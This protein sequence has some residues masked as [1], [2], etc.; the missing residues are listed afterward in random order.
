MPPVRNGKHPQ[1]MRPA[2]SAQAP[3]AVGSKGKSLPNNPPPRPAI[4]GTKATAAAAS[5]RPVSVQGSGGMRSPAVQLPSQPPTASPRPQISTMRVGTVEIEV[6]RTPSQVIYRLPKDRTVNSLTPEEHKYVMEAINKLHGQQRVRPQRPTPQS[7]PQLLPSQT[8]RASLA[9]PQPAATKTY[10]ISTMTATP[11]GMRPVRPRPPS[12][13]PTQ[14]PRPLLPIQARTASLS[15]PLATSAV[16]REA[17]RPTN[18]TN[19]RG[20]AAT[21]K[22][23][24]GAEPQQKTLSAV[25]TQALIQKLRNLQNS[26]SLAGSL[27]AK[28]TPEQL[29][30]FLSTSLPMLASTTEPSS[31]QVLT[32][33][34][35]MPESGVQTPAS[36]NRPFTMP[37]TPTRGSDGQSLGTGVEKRRQSKAGGQPPKRQCMYSHGNGDSSSYRLSSPS[38]VPSCPL[39]SPMVAATLTDSAAPTGGQEE[40]QSLSSIAKRTSSPSLASASMLASTI[41][42][43]PSLLEEPFASI[44][45]PRILPCPSNAAA[46][47]TTTHIPTVSKFA[48]DAGAAADGSVTS[49]Q[50]PAS[51]CKQQKTSPPRAM[52]AIPRASPEAVLKALRPAFI[53]R[54]PRELLEA[55]IATVKSRFRAALNADYEA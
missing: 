35:S 11:T 25:D 23:Y 45:G 28:L 54:P 32:A 2:N 14:Q 34:P 24:T 46:V 12:D 22:S 27:A 39:D 8:N 50:A 47:T 33:A 49:T 53:S 37:A 7:P 31:P 4:P 43:D 1:T 16:S 41:T 6:V 21:P 52:P 19:V 30:K 20:A 38:A 55:H 42:R 29:L 51:P 44:G 26:Q 3:A 48:S 36:P 18:I 10:P 15:R 40:A 13:A 17:S 9:R 5:P